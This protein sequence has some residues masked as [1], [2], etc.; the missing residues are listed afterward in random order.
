MWSWSSARAQAA[1]VVVVVAALAALFALSALRAPAASQAGAM[2]HQPPAHAGS[3]SVS[4]NSCSEHDVQNAYMAG[5]SANECVQVCMP[6][7]WIRAALAHGVRIGGTCAAF[8]CTELLRSEISGN[9]MRLITFRC[10]G[11]LPPASPG[12]PPPPASPPPPPPPANCRPP[13][14][15]D[16]ALTSYPSGYVLAYRAAG[17]NGEWGAQCGLNFNASGASNA[18]I[19]CR[20]LGYAGA[21][22]S[23]T[24]IVPN[25]PELSEHKVVGG[26]VACPSAEAQRAARHQLGAL[27]DCEPA[28]DSRRAC[29]GHSLDVRVHCVGQVGPRAEPPIRYCSAEEAAEA[30]EEA[31]ERAEARAREQRERE[32]MREGHE[33]EPHTREPRTREQHEREQHERAAREPRPPRVRTPKPPQV[34]KP[35]ESDEDDPASAGFDQ[36]SDMPAVPAAIRSEWCARHARLAPRRTR[37]R[38]ALRSVPSAGRALRPSRGCGPMPCAVLLHRL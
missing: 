5:T 8:G 35:P 37:A 26:G 3:A 13:Q 31:K 15:G 29:D 10:P 11:P 4:N 24:R 27:S 34:P 12:P 33:R 25:A 21:N 16:V 1:R 17:R 2:R 23:A 19:V 9:S 18:D 20:S 14:A 22:S 7:T 38:R 30:A 28:A 36:C 6:V 32:R